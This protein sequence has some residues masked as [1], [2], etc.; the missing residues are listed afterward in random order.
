MHFGKELL[1]QHV[2][3]L[4]GIHPQDLPYATGSVMIASSNTINSLLLVEGSALHAYL[5]VH[6]SHLAKSPFPMPLGSH[7]LHIRPNLPRLCDQSRIP[8]GVAI[9]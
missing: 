8:V 4:A 1:R 5:E 2:R 9:R 7:L 6:V 3:H